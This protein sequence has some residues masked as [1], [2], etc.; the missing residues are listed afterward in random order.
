MRPTLTLSCRLFI[1]LKSLF[2]LMARTSYT[3]YCQDIKTLAW[4]HGTTKKAF[5]DLTRTQAAPILS[6]LKDAFFC[7]ISQQ[8]S[9]HD[10]FLCSSAIVWWHPG[11][12]TIMIIDNFKGKKRNKQERSIINHHTE[13]NQFMIITI[14][15]VITKLLPSCLRAPHRSD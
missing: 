10:D 7:I 9:M 11:A 8:L 12:S 1:L 5:N 15:L 13:Y 4:I 3:P 6:F 14:Q 2:L